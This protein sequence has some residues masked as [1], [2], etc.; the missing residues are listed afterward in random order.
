MSTSDKLKRFLITFLL[1]L[2]PFLLI[3]IVIYYQEVTINKKILEIQAIENLNGQNE[4]IVNEF[5]YIVSD[6]MFLSEQY[7]LQQ[8]LENDS[9]PQRRILENGYH[10]FA[11]RKKM[12]EQIR[13]LNET[14]MEII[15]I[16]GNAGNPFIVPPQQL[17]SKGKRYYFKDTF[18]LQQGNVFVSPFDLNIEQGQIEYPLK[19]MIR[20]GT[21]VFDKAG[22]KRGIILFNYLGEKLLQKLHKRV[23]TAS[24]EFMLLNAEGFWLK[25][26]VSQDEWGFMFQNGIDK[27]FGN[28][29]S[30][31]WQKITQAK[32]GQFY[33][34][35]GFFSFSTIYPLLEGQKSSSGTQKAFL[36]SLKNISVLEYHWKLISYVPISVLQINTRK[37]LKHIAIPFMALVLLIMSIS[38][39]LTKTYIIRV[40]ADTLLRMKNKQLE[41][42]AKQ[43]KE[44]QQDKLYRINKAFERFIPYEFIRLLD[45]DSILDVQL[46]DQVAKEMTI[47]FSDIRGFT[48]ISEKMTPQENFDFI[49]SYLG[50]M[51]PIIAL[52]HGFIDKY[53]GDAIMALF[54][55]S[56]DDALCGA[57][58]MLR[59]LLKYNQGRQAYDPISIGIGLNTG[60]LMLG[61]IGGKNRMDGTVI[62]DA[63]NLAARIE[64]MTKM[65]GTRLLISQYTY[66]HL[67]DISQYAIRIIDI[68]KAK[69]KSEPVTVY[70]VFDADSPN[71]FEL[72]MK[73]RDNFEFGLAYYHQKHIN[74]AIKCFKQVL[75]IYPDDQATHIYLKRCL[76]K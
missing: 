25:G 34:N 19:P 66:S 42:F 10:L 12:Y 5:N 3:A 76:D 27:T 8:L 4:Q 16:N 51:E 29:F 67:N 26:S 47:L 52:N 61:T 13:F 49:N 45:K 20:F 23:A 6:L 60:A 15:R 44:I 18:M 41:A 57:I 7:E 28:R 1:L 50:Q 54:P 62:S 35:K 38:A 39:F 64:N 43:L 75:Q 56:A 31:E 70:E 73:T 58:A 37:I 2:L 17:Q 69:G 36:P 21:P 74:K 24:C 71:I 68:V 59:K 30:E 32:S 72:K 40:N 46:G 53:I 11:S 33:T 22:K 63:V 9:I 48:S 65:Y 14:G 55:S